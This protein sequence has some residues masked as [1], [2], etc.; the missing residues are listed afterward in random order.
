MHHHHC[1]P[2][3]IPKKYKIQK[4]SVYNNELT[5]EILYEIMNGKE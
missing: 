3:H 4:S 1:P 5:K 2:D